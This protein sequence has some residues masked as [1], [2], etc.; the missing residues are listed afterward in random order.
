MWYVDAK[1]SM[2][3]LAKQWIN[4][5]HQQWLVNNRDTNLDGRKV[6]LLE[7]KDSAD[8]VCQWMM[9]LKEGYICFR[10][11]GTAEAI[12]QHRSEWITIF[13]RMPPAKWK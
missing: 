10:V 2:E 7:W 9:R 5:R 8:L 11:E 6:R 13:D 4:E 3:A 1:K 12:E